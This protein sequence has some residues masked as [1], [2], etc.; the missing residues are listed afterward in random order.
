MLAARLALS[1]SLRF[2]NLS[3]LCSAVSAVL[4]ARL[5]LSLSLRFLNLSSLCLTVSAVLVVRLALSLSLRFHTYRLYVGLAQA[6]P[7]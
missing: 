1:L 3:S 6:R 2:L 5:A 4:A 7:N